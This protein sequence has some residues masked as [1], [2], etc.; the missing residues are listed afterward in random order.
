MCQVVVQI[1]YAGTGYDCHRRKPASKIC[2]AGV[3]ALGVTCAFAA[4]V[5]A[6]KNTLVYPAV[7]HPGVFKG[8]LPPCRI[9]ANVASLTVNEIGINQLDRTLS[10]VNYF[11]SGKGTIFVGLVVQVDA[12][13]GK[14]STFVSCHARH[15][16]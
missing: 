13:G 9:L 5:T 8:G 1:A 4:G 2:C 7:T 3:N 15:L 10:S 14:L 11:A 16:L 6:P 12:S